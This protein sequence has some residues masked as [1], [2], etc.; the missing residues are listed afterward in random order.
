MTKPFYTHIVVILDRSGSMET[1]KHDAI[2][3]FNSFIAEQKKVPGEATLTLV[4]FDH[5]YNVLCDFSPLHF[6]PSLNLSTFVPRGTTALLDAIGR[7]ITS[8]GQRLAS[9][10][11]YQRPSKVVFAV[12]TDGQENASKEFNRARIFDMIT[13]QE[14]KYNWVF[15]FL[16]SSLDAIQDATVWYG[17]PVKWTYTYS[18]TSEGTRNAF[19]ALASSVTSYRSTDNE[20]SLTDASISTPSTTSKSKKSRSASQ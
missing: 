16:S 8:V 2:G 1:L 18:S 13:H 12:L 3:G 20:F 10:P 4:Q 5:E 11:E 19:V 15:A 9:M 7:T 14:Q 6:A 17:I